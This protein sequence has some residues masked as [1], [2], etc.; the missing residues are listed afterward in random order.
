MESKS[1]KNFVLN[2]DL[3]GPTPSL[4]IFK[5]HNYKSMTSSII[6]IIGILIL[7]AFSIYSIIDFFKF[8][9]PTIV[10]FKDSTQTKST[11][12]YL[13]DILFMFQ[14][15][16]TTSLNKQESFIEVIGFLIFENDYSKNKI[17]RIE[18]C[19]LGKNI[20]I[21]HKE[22][23]KKFESST[24][25]NHTDYYCLNKE[26]SNIAIFDDKIMGESYLMITV[27]EL[28]LYPPKKKILRYII[29]SD[30]INHLDRNKP[31]KSNYDWGD[32][33]AFSLSTKIYT[34]ILLNYIQYETDNGLFFSNNK[35]YKGIEFYN[36]EEKMPMN[37][38]DYTEE[39]NHNS[40]IEREEICIFFLRINGKSFERY[41]RT[42]P[43]LPSLF[44]DV[45]STI[46]LIIL[47]Y[48]LLTDNLYS[49]KMGVEIIKRILYEEIKINSK[50]KKEEEDKIEQ[51]KTI[52]HSVNAYKENK[53]WEET[54]DNLSTINKIMIQNKTDRQNNLNKEKIKNKTNLY[55][56][57]KW[58]LEKMNRINFRHFLFYYFSCC[59]TK[60]REIIKKCNEFVDKEISIDNIMYKMLKLRNKEILKKKQLKEIIDLLKE[61]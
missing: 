28:E 20:D 49:N 50:N 9:N 52:K 3:L 43:K 33:K 30:S 40:T 41:K 59:F 37:Y 24:G 17:V 46:E 34:N 19:E 18:R 25:Q 51:I 31:L 55:M 36:Q 11:T 29:Q 23:I 8:N 22:S 58:I 32:S 56:D 1:S 61:I 57:N 27:N 15:N 60:E 2:F 5:E 13:K 12:I 47:I 14:I 10:Y 6:S 48:N 54:K 44:A 21:K 26:D 35:I 4:S 45:K 38:L 7:I 53:N 39:A 42:Y 16:D